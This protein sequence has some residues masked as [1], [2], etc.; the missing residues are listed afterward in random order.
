[1]DTFFTVLFSLVIVYEM[2][3]LAIDERGDTISEKNVALRHW[4]MPLGR[5]I[6]DVFVVWYLFHIYIDA[7]F[8][9]APSAS[10]VDLVLVV[11]VAGLSWALGPKAPVV[12]LP[13]DAPVIRNVEF[14]PDGIVVGDAP[15]E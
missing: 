3:A 8:T 11:A 4:R 10:W 1:M 5:I 15:G 13:K 9:R 12:V 14:R 2:V 6:F 7:G